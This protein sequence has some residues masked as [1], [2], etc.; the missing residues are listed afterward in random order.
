MSREA[1]SEC[2]KTLHIWDFKEIMS[3]IFVG[4]GITHFCG[5]LGDK[6]KLFNFGGV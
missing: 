5:A 1:R 3:D 4:D 2:A 6:M